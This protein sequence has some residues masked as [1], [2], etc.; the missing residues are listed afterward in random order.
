M[1]DG[2][3]GDVKAWSGRDDLVRLFVLGENVE[4]QRIEVQFSDGW[5]VVVCEPTLRKAWSVLKSRLRIA[6]PLRLGLRTEG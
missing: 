3:W 1:S 4:G 6:S 2:G 5:R